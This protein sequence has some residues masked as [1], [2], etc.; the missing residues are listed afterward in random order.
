MEA[1]AKHWN[2]GGCFTMLVRSP[3]ISRGPCDPGRRWLKVTENGWDSHIASGEKTRVKP[4]R[5]DSL[6]LTAATQSLAPVDML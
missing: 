3:E 5:M 6:W 1:L 4:L 2:I